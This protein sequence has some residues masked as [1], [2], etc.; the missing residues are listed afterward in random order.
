MSQLAERRSLYPVRMWPKDLGVA[1]VVLL[2]LAIAWALY[3]QVD[4]RTRLYQEPD[5]AFRMAYPANWTASQ[6]INDIL[7]KVEDPETESAFKTTLTVE[8]RDLDAANPPTLPAL[9]DR[10][11]AQRRPLVGFRFFGNSDATV[12]G[13]KSAQ[14]DYAYVV[15]PIDSPRRTALPVVVRAQEYIVVARDRT[16]Y[17]TLAAPND[18]F[19]GAK[20]RF[21]RMIQT[22]KIQ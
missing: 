22:V 10:R 18:E 5:S 8:R 15:Q 3:N 1:A 17:I 20:A 12:D 7:L 2:A 6:S 21:E 9:I 11:I 19:S 16:Y 14:L 13:A 4:N